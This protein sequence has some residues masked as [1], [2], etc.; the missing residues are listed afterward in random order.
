MQN[1][2]RID[3]WISQ[4]PEFPDVTGRMA[5]KIDAEGMATAL[6]YAERGM[7]P[8]EALRSVG[9][10]ADTIRRYESRADDAS[11]PWGLPLYEFFEMLHDAYRMGAEARAAALDGTSEAQS[12]DLDPTL[13]APA[14]FQ[15]ESVQDQ[16]TYV[17]ENGREVKRTVKLNPRQAPIRTEK[18]VP[19][20]T[21]RML[22]IISD[23]VYRIY[24]KENTCPFC[25]EAR[26]P[27][28]AELESRGQKT[29]FTEA[30]IRM[31]SVHWVD[32]EHD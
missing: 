31:L 26:P 5:L 8:R 13:V 19:E 1:K 25:K 4:L 27:S 23:Q 12:G 32:P 29:L 3:Y 30:E 20:S 2:S 18:G 14:G 9:L 24:L 11:D 22:G 21:Q 10:S 7:K 6:V 28:R 17:D 15:V 16:H